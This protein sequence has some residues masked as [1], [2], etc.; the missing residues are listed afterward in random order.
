MPVTPL[1]TPPI[2]V[3]GDVYR[4]M[5]V[6]VTATPSQD[7][8][9]TDNDQNALLSFCGTQKVNMLYLDI[10][11]YIS[12]GSFNSTKQA[13]I[14]QFVDAAHKSGIK[15]FALAGSIDWGVNQHWVGRNILG[16]LAQF[17][18]MG[19]SASQQFDGIMLDVEYWT[20][21]TTYPPSTNLP[22]LCELVKSAKKV[23]GNG[24]QVGCFT[25]FF[26]KDNTGARAT[27]TYNGKTAQDGEHLMDVCDLVVVGA[28]R[29]H[30]SDNGTDGP[31]QISLYQPWYD[32]AASNQ[33][34]VAALMCGAETINVS[35]AYVT[36]FG[37]SKA[38][39]ETEQTTVSAAFSPTANLVHFGAAIHSYDGWKAMS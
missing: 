2:P 22:G 8:L 36:Y 35:P 37:M 25:G 12:S 18:A 4:G 30:A 16:E 26:L 17:N 39:M 3:N 6:W 19:A 7:P 21:E 31:G 28:Y 20:D 32:Y 24:C 15:V 1:S 27:I 10:W 14:R 34:Q 13:R 9:D 33:G 5:F 38:A 29:N 11:Q 23:L